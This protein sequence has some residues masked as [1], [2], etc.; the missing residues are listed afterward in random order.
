MKKEE[1]FKEGIRKMKK[2][3]K[4]WRREEVGIYGRAIYMEERIFEI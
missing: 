4:R 3:A 1:R 2:V